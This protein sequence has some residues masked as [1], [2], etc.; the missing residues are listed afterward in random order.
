MAKVAAHLP[1]GFVFELSAHWT[2][3]ELVIDHDGEEV[4]RQSFTTGLGAAANRLDVLRRGA[5]S[6]ADLH[7]LELWIDR[8]SDIEGMRDRASDVLTYEAA[9]DTDLWVGFKFREGIGSTVADETGN[10]TLALTGAPAWITSPDADRMLYFSTS[11]LPA[12]RVDALAA[13]IRPI[14][15]D[16]SND[17]DEAVEFVDKLEAEGHTEDVGGPPLPGVITSPGAQP[18]LPSYTLGG[19]SWAGTVQPFTEVDQSGIAPVTRYPLDVLRRLRFDG[20]PIEVW[21]YAEV[22]PWRGIA[23]MSNIL[24]WER[25]DGEKTL[26]GSNLDRWG[27]TAY[28]E[29]IQGVDAKRPEFLSDFG[30]G[31]PAVAFDGVD[32]FLKSEATIAIGPTFVEWLVFRNADTA[33]FPVPIEQSV[34]WDPGPGHLLFFDGSA[35]L[36][37]SSVKR[38][39]LKSQKISFSAVAS[40]FDG[41]W[42]A[43][44]IEHGGTHVSHR[45]FLNGI[46]VATGTAGGDSDNVNTGTA[47]DSTY[48]GSRAGTSLFFNGHMRERLTVSPKPSAAII[49]LADAEILARW[50]L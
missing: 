1:R 43:L 49:G 32:E 47:T 8:S 42:V 24:I 39:A 27:E 30:D 10:S 17:P 14:F 36:I 16:L 15:S 23:N 12:V 25:A 5:D 7:I 45:I 26:S 37:T 35:D 2:G 22:V 11:P 21:R 13:S 48:L 50:G 38:A 29:E 33:A 6:G 3:D 20:A 40:A 41:T 28:T 19:T 46:E 4:A 18:L 34:N 44:R 31:M 9:V